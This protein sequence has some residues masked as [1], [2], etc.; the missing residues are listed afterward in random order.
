MSGSPVFDERGHLVAIHAKTEKPDKSYNTEAC[1]ALPLKPNPDYGNNWGISVKTFLK[2][3]ESLPEGLKSILPPVPSPEPEPPSTPSPSPPSPPS[4]S[5]TPKEPTPDV[6]CG[7]FR[8]P[9]EVCP[10]EKKP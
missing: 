4:P 7:P 5:P 3:Q 6:N 2:F 8:D 10:E 1:K 9:L